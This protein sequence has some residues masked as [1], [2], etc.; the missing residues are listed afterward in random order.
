MYSK[1]AYTQLLNLMQQQAYRFAS[2]EEPSSDGQT[3]K[4]VYLRHDI[5]YSPAW[6]L[7]FA[8][9]NASQNVAGTFFFQLRTPIYNLLAYPTLNIVHEI[10]QLGQH[11]GL[12]FTISAENLKDDRSLIQ[13][14]EKDFH[15]AREHIKELRP[16]FS[17][18]NPSLMPD[19]MN[20]GKDLSFPGMVNAYSRY[21]F[22]EVKYVSDSNI[23]YT[24]SQFQEI[25][26]SNCPKLQL[27]FHPFQW[28]AG[29]GDMQQVLANTWV[30]MIREQ[31]TEFCKNHIYRCL[32]PIGMPAEWLEQFAENIGNYSKPKKHDE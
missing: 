26:N 8:K 28:L 9:I 27:L 6:A 21:F 23:R 25:I 11:V 13:Q 12:H 17:W 31:E 29:G 20:R 2:F 32:F 14:V 24:V 5:D 1:E 10:V 7:E 22:E 16:V 3:D 15:Y 19:I 30:Q 4:L 18:H